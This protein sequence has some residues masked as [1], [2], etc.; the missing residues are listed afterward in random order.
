MQSIF[1][2]LEMC[3]IYTLVAFHL[4]D[5]GFKKLCT[6]VSMQEI[7]FDINND[8]NIFCYILFSLTQSII[9]VIQ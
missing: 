7:L 6:N 4:F 8:Y 3:L 9:F 1:D 5:K 2:L